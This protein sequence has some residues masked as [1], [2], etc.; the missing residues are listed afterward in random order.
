LK[1]HDCL[2]VL[3]LPPSATPEEIQRAY[4][5]LALQHHPDRTGDDPVNHERFCRVTEAY[6]SLKRV[7]N[8]RAAAAQ[9]GPCY[10]CEETAEVFRGPGGLDFC[11]D[12]LLG[13]HKRFLPLPRIETI[14]C[15][16][17]IFF[18]ALAL[19]LLLMTIVGDDW[20]HGIA[21]MVCTGLATIALAVNVWSAD[22]IERAPVTKR[23]R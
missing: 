2:L 18:L 16:V 8:V 5:R 17:A 11:A 14:R 10:R 4:K 7:H 15:F 13:R 20:R 21:G 1:Y 19:I 3:G 12:C 9:V 23:K 6:A 22:T